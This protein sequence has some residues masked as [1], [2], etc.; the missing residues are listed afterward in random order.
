MTADLVHWI[1]EVMNVMS[2]GVL[3]EGNTAYTR[4]SE[5]PPSTTIAVLARSTHTHTHT[6]TLVFMVNGDYT[7]VIGVMFFILYK[8]HLYR[9]ITTLH[10]N[11]TL[12]VKFVHVYF[13]KKTTI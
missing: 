10:L 2:S 6:H 3:D 5:R 13:K 11:L 4:A 7:G 8:P 1:S 9:P 12:T